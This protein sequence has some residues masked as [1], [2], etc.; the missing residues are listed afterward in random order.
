MYSL[1]PGT[2]DV[3]PD[4]WDTECTAWP[5]GQWMFGLTFGIVDVQLG[6]RDNRFW[7]DLWD[8]GCTAWPQGQWM[9]GLTSGT[10]DVQLG[11]RDGGCMA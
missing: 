10:V 2:V 9:F 3:Q 7:L 6:P 1:A 4:L 8:T 5:Q 11:P